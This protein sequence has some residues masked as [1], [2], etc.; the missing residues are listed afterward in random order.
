MQL[1]V[2]VDQPYQV[3]LL[4]LRVLAGGN[5]DVDLGVGAVACCDV[6]VDVVVKE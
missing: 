5:N 4:D 6:G 2:G 1:D 3:L